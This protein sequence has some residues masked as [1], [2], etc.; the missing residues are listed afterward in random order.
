MHKPHIGI[1]FDQHIPEDIFREFESSVKADGL[2]L[3]VEPNKE[4]MGA[5]MCAEWFI[6]P[7]IMIFVGKSYFDGFLKEMGKDHYLSLKENI[8]NLT[9][10]V[11]SEPRIEPTIFATRGK[12]SSNNPFS[13]ACALHA[14]TEDGY[15]FKL[16]LPKYDKNCDYKLIVKEFMEFLT[17]YHLGLKS[18]DSIGF[19][20]TEN[21]AQGYMVF[22]HYN[23][24]SNKIEWLNHN[25]YR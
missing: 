6:F 2:N 22:V 3:I 9:S 11:M 20:S 8:S 10:T 1:I 12:L 7:A 25:D 17:D 13:L 21:M 5:M 19:C 24:E 23:F 14:D 16:L 18:L 15:T 4:P